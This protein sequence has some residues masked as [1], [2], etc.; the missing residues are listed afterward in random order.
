MLV[1]G[2]KIFCASV[3]MFNRK[4]WRKESR[5]CNFAF[6]STETNS[7]F[8]CSVTTLAIRFSCS[9]N[10][11]LLYLTSVTIDLLSLS[12]R[13]I[14]NNTSIHPIKF[15]VMVMKTWEWWHHYTT[16]P[17]L[18]DL[19][20]QTNAVQPFIKPHEVCLIRFVLGENQH[21]HIYVNGTQIKDIVHFRKMPSSSK[22]TVIE[23]FVIETV[24]S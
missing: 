12:C 15:C 18:K 7:C 3:L 24:D 4:C 1:D 21:H 23:G 2:N 13:Q 22:L 16:L 11:P 17:W 5:Q 19:F 8:K 6:S 9:K 14:T 10:Q 20:S